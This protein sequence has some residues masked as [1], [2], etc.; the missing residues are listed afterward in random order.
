MRKKLTPTLPKGEAILALA[1][2][3]VGDRYVLGT[4]T[5]MRDPNYHGPWDC[6]QLASWAL[7]QVAKVVYGCASDQVPDDGKGVLDAYTGYWAR[8]AAKLPA[9]RVHPWV[10]A[11]TPGAF[12]LRVPGGDGMGGHIVISDGNGGTVEAMGTKYG[13]VTA[14][15][16]RRRWDMGIMP[17]GVEWATPRKLVHLKPP[18]GP[19]L[20]IGAVGPLVSDL[21]AKLTRAGFSTKGVDGV[22]GPNTTAAVL[23]FQRHEGLIADG[24]AGPVTNAALDAHLAGVIS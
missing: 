24:E 1:A 13:V 8:D 11:S 21:Q 9:T 5:P 23:A 16:D 17:G 3:R 20:R 15:A 6:A 12:L 7:Y 4:L 22:F 14:S 18:S 19:V 2:T 10:A